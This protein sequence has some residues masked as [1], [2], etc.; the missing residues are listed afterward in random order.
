[1]AD[2]EYTVELLP[3]EI[4]FLHS[5]KLTR[6][7]ISPET[8][9]LKKVSD[10]SNA[11]VITYRYALYGL[12]EKEQSKIAQFT[13][14]TFPGNCGMMI[15]LHSAITSSIFYKKGLGTFLNK[16]RMRLVKDEGY[17]VLVCTDRVSNSHNIKILNKNNWKEIDTFTNRRSGNS[18]SV[19]SIHLTNFNRDTYV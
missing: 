18:I 9:I 6:G 7:P 8:F 19:R 10:A 16:L 4:K 1:M 15:A 2:N 17:T 5:L 14:S 11:Y 12:Y 3:N 13:L